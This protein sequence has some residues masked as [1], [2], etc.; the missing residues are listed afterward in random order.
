MK[1]DM[2][3]AWNEAMRLIAANRQVLPVVA[4]VFFFLPYAAFML[5]FATEMA[6]LEAAQS[7]NPDPQALTQTMMAFYGRIWWVFAII[8]VLQGIGMLGLL[9]L[10]TDRGRPTVGEALAIGAK[11]LLPYIGAQIITGM[12]MMLVMVVPIAVGAGVSVAA[13]VLVGVAALAVLVY[14]FTKFLLVPPVIA[15]ERVAN[16]IAA[17]GR[18]W[19]L[20]KGNSFR[21]FLF[22]FLIIIAIAVVGGVANMVV[23]VVLALAGPEVA[24][25]GQAIVSG[26]IN[27]VWITIF[28]AVLA[29]VHRQLAGPSPER[30]S[31]TFE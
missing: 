3:T 19:R 13:G 1:F 11:L 8:A 20:T 14:L 9:A 31:E 21:L 25:A 30:V 27:A 28:L 10:L 17:L 22:V 16:P 6:G 5:L 15:I 29:A 24:S 18:S 26:A 4:G 7:A 12:L 23:G 2:T